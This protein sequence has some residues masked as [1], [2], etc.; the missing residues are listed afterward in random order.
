MSRIP[1]LAAAVALGLG[2]L[3]ATPRVSAQLAPSEY[4]ARRSA[5]AASIDSGVVLAHGG[6]ETVNYWPN[7]FQLPAFHYLTGFDESDAVLVMVKRRGTVASTMFVPTRTV[8]EA[9][10]VGSRTAPGALR[11]AIGIP[12]RDIAELRPA[13]DSLVAGGLPL[14]VVPD[15]QSSDYAP[16]DSLTRGAR[17][18]SALRAARPGLR[19]VSLDS[20]VNELRAKKSPAEVA[21]LRRAAQISVKGHIEAMKATAPGC[22]ENEIQALLDGS[23]RRFGG[24]RPAYGSIVGSGTNATILHY[25]EDNRVMKEGELLLIDAAS[26]FDHYA[27]DVT[28][29]LPV[30]GTFSPAQREIYQLVRDAQEAYVRPIKA[31][32]PE[33]ASSDAARA[34]MAKGLTRLG[35]TESETATFD[36]PPGMQCPP[37][38]CSQRNLYVW[39]GYGGHGI[40][41]EV[42][43]PAQY[44]T[45]GNVFKVGDVTTVEPG[46]YVDPAFIATIPDTPKNRAMR[47]KLAAAWKKY[48]GM[49]VRIEDDYAV[50]ESGTEWLSKGAPRELDEV[51]AMM[52][53][54]APELP[55]AGTCGPKA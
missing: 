47:A 53:Q 21:L 39:H 23:F 16:Q 52:K 29:T 14:Y 48:E 8:A 40:G 15:V 32:V 27:A 33:A 41:L 11:S 35:L 49:G 18:I 42:H 54:R 10:W 30:S 2:S 38:G 17:L 31:G 37:T 34:V 45:G 20:V 13:I 6:V 44:Y 51:E 28:R 22:G 24:D 5:L 4:A 36:P 3:V 19:V 7:F 46:V 43:D 25:M 50:T 26:S 55:G 1:S 12:G 9:R